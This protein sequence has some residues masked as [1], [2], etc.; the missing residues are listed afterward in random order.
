MASWIMEEGKKVVESMS[1]EL[2]EVRVE[3]EAYSIY[4]ASM[5]SPP[6]CLRGAERIAERGCCS[7]LDEFWR[8]GRRRSGEEGPEV[9]KTCPYPSFEDGAYSP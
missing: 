6:D 2:V 4:A 3:R 9:E 8:K 5:K 1:E 7:L